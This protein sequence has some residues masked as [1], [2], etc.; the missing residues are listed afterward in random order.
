MWIPF[1]TPSPRRL[2]PNRPVAVVVVVSALL[3][4]TTTQAQQVVFD[5]RSLRVDSSTS[6]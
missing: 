6:P 4:A 1:S 5:P 2:R 3:A